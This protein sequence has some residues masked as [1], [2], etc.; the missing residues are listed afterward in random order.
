MGE[1]GA[2]ELIVLALGVA[3]LAV[4]VMIVVRLLSKPASKTMP[5][6]LMPCGACAQQM[7][8]RA[9]ACPHCGEP[10]DARA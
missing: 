2:P 3:I 8:P 9:N 4:P 6:G 10:N 1:L 5:V 7:S